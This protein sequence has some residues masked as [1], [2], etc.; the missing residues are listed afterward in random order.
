MRL[1][2]FSMIIVIILFPSSNACY[3][4]PYSSVV[5]FDCMRSSLIEEVPGTPGIVTL[6]SNCKD[7]R[8]D[9]RSIKTALDI[10]SREY[11]LQ[12]NVSESAAMA[13]LSG[14]RIELSAIPRTVPAA[15]SVEGIFLQGEVAVSGLALDR[16]NIWVEVRTSKISS[17]SLIHELVH[18]IIWRKNIVHADPDHEGK[19]FSGWT[20]EHTKL[21]KRV[22]KILLDADI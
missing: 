4:Q 10:F 6:T 5:E 7:Y 15:Y 3:Y 20:K 14:L 1:L 18:T 8:F 12:F 21:I 17:S 16:D 22:N 13:L 2:K 11:A 9:V 19:E